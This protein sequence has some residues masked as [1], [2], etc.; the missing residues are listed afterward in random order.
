MCL[1]ATTFISNAGEWSS[2]IKVTSLRTNT[3][4]VSPIISMQDM[5][6]NSNLAYLDPNSENHS[7]VISLLLASMMAEK[8]IRLLCDD[9]CA[10]SNRCR[11][12]DVEVFN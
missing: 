3:V 2:L 11:V 4:N 5:C 1:V 6:V 9:T 12:I 8:E 10:S 7:E